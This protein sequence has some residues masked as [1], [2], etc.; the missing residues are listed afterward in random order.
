MIFVPGFLAAKDEGLEG[1]YGFLDQVEALKWVKA[2][3]GNFGGNSDMIT[4]HGHSAGAADVGFL[5][6]S[7]LSKGL[8]SFLLWIYQFHEN[9]T[10]QN[11]QT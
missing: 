8:G 10:R 6:T 9:K 11:S 2:N 3:I 5:T 4:I 1:I 7:P